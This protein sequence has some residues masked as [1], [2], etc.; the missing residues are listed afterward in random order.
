MAPNYNTLPTH[1]H[2]V[3]RA[4]EKISSMWRVIAGI[5]AFVVEGEQYETNYYDRTPH[6]RN[7]IGGFMSNH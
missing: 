6:Y 2:I 4:S 1:G 7:V 3:G 5:V